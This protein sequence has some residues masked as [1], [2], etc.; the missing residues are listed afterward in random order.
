[1]NGFSSGPQETGLPEP[2]ARGL[3]RSS[4]NHGAEDQ[5]SP[6][7]KVMAATLGGPTCTACQA[8]HFQSLSKANSHWWSGLLPTQFPGGKLL[9]VF[10]P[11]LSLFWA[12]HWDQHLVL[13][14]QFT[15]YF[16]NLWPPLQKHYYTSKL[17]FI[18]CLNYSKSELPDWLFKMKIWH[19][20]C[21][22]ED[23]L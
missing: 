10:L 11:F 23:T 4:L 13:Y 7:A 12:P 15:K 20:I 3:G 6:P 8:T 9:E 2:W 16:L 18:F 22:L 19:V 14:I 17:S 21:Q 1:M 5:T